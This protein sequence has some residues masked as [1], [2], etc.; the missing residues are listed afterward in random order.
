[1]ERSCGY[2]SG[3]GQLSDVDENNQQRLAN[4]VLVFILVS[5]NGNFKAPI[6][7]YVIDS[8]TGEEK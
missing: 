5:I 2:S 7:H 1:M 8:L 4:I 3:G 6:A